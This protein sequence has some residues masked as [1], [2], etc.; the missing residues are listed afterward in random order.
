MP[1]EFLIKMAKSRDELI[2]RI[3]ENSDIV[4]IISGYF[5]LSRA[6]NNFKALCPFHRE[7]S[8]SFSVNPARQFFYCFGCGAGGDVFK[9]VM[10]YE[11]VDFPTAARM[12][13]AKAGIAFEPTR[14]ESGDGPDKAELYEANEKAAQIFLD[15]LLTKPEGEPA[16][17]YLKKR[18]FSSE[19]AREFRMG[20]APDRWDTLVSRAGKEFK[21]QT[22]EAAGLIIRGDASE[23]AR[24]S[25]HDRFRNRVLFAIQDEQG[26]VVGFSGR[27]MGDAA[28]AAK[29]VNSPETPV[30]HKGRLLY[31]FHRARRAMADSRE[32]II[33]EGQIDVIRCHIAGFAN[34]VAAQGTAFTADH[35]RAVARYADRVTIVFDADEAGRNASLRA[36]QIF[37]QSGLEVRIALLPENEDPDSMLLASG[38]GRFKE[39]LAQAESMLRF[40]L[41]ML[42]GRLD[43]K[44]ESGLV[45]A[46]SELLDSVRLAPNEVQRSLLLSEAS[47]LLGVGEK[48]L[49]RELNKKN[50]PAAPAGEK[51]PPPESR[52]SA[53]ARETALVEQLLLNP[54]FSGLVKQYLPPALF[55]D[56]LCRKAAL[57]VIAAKE[58]NRDV[59]AAIAEADDE[60]RSL[61]RIAAAAAAGKPK[62]TGNLA[63]AEDSTKSLILEIHKAG[64]ARKRAKIRKELA[65]LR[66]KQGDGGA[67]PEIK[68]LENEC[69]Q[70]A[71]DIAKLKTWESA[72]DLL[73]LL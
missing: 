36:A 7:K 45:R 34:A 56:D 24:Q 68:R 8:P 63:T 33:C 2:E 38:P 71:Y 50:A 15:F 55:T 67:N 32:A 54:E 19:S 10:N 46:S 62:V 51:E 48:A 39:V 9:F 16:R 20:F 21:L 29:Y 66:L 58:K 28:G 5:P 70:T 73:A 59:F 30:F 60:Q 72:V 12:L 41:E 61:C 35:A 6:G 11:K 3:R 49:S 13:A 64:L 47:K 4:D 40:Q 14:R 31:A 1:A 22:L 52:A 69:I 57:T 42:S 65:A 25:Y 26:R 44:T 37:L 18:G 53:P 17:K 27:L 23:P 43:L